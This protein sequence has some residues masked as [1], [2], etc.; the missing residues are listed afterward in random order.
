MPLDG[1]IKKII[2]DLGSTHEAFKKSVEEELAQIKKAGQPDPLTTQ[3]IQKLNDE[4]DR[5]TEAK[6]QHDKHL[7]DLEKKLA[8]QAVS[9]SQGDDKL[10]AEVKAMNHHIAANSNDRFDELSPDSYQAYKAAFGQYLRKGDKSFG[11]AE[12]KTLSV[13]GDADG[14]YLVTPD[15]TGQIVTRIFETSPMRQICTVQPIGTDALEGLRDTDQVSAGWVG[16]QSARPVTGTPQLGQ[17]RIPVHEMYAQPD[18]TQKMLDDSSIDVEA[19][20]ASKVSERF[21]RVEN[22]SFVGGDGVVQPRGFT[23]YPTAAT[24]DASRAWGTFEHIGTGVSGAFPASNPANV[25]FDLEAALKPGYLVN[26]KFVTRRSVIQL[27]R[28]FVDSTGQYLWQPSLQAGRPQTLIGY[29]IFYA[30]DMPAV[31]ANSL[32][33]ALGDFAQGYTI[34]DR[35]GMRTLRDPYSAKPF[36]RFYTTKRTGGDVT[37]FECIKFLRF[38]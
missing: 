16:E 26:A 11:D 15:R 21:I 9:G 37:Q 38:G 12:R 20:L 31:A 2:E 28:K 13:G 27:V 29:E 24:S 25:F 17:W 36:V 35:L 18:S 32:S 30:E 33:L 3:K 19:W 23:T 34:V 5:L 14:G 6:A 7:A 8:R 22:A 10:A 4:L 1:E